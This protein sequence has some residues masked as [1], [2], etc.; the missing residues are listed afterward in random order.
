MSIKILAN[1]G[2]D[3]AGRKILTEAG[4]TVVSDKV[5]QDQLAEAIVRE[6]SKLVATGMRTSAAATG[7]GGWK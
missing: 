4:C 7:A 6:G 2:I 3:A 1:D 5:A